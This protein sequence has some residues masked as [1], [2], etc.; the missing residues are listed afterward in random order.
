MEYRRLNDCTVKD[1]FPLPRIDDIIDS[2]QGQKY[3]SSLDLTSGYWQVEMDK[4]SAEKTAFGVPIGHFELKAIPFGL[5]NAV[6]T[7]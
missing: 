3:F 6:A 5:C 1:T 7:F 4:D 2:L